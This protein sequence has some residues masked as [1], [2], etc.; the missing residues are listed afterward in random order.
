MGLLL[1]VMTSAKHRS[2]ISPRL[3]Y[4]NPPWLVAQIRQAQFFAFQA[5][6]ELLRY[7]LQNRKAVEHAKRQYWGSAE[8]PI[9]GLVP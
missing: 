4:L 7:L 1:V 9:L 8:Q 2:T 6:E 3:A 5:L